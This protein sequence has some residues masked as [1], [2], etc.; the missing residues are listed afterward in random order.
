[1]RR[2][3]VTD[4]TSVPPA[5]M[6]KTVQP[7]KVFGLRL[8]LSKPHVY[9]KELR[10]NGLNNCLDNS[11]EEDCG[12]CGESSTRCPDGT[13]LSPEEKCDGQVHCSDGSD[14]PITCGNV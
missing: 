2:P 1:M 11:D 6:R 7:L 5:L 3:A 10:C 4:K 14:E 8:D 13:C 9:P 12:Q